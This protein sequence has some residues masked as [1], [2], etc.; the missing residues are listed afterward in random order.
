[1]EPTD[2]SGLLSLRAHAK[3]MIG[4]GEREW[5]ARGFARV[6]ESGVVDVVGCD[7]GRAEGI[8]GALKVIDLVEKADAWFNAHAWSS[9]VVT[10]ASLALSASTPRCLV[11]E[12]KPIANPMQHELVTDPFRHVNGWVAVRRAPGLGVEVDARVLNKYRWD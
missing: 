2:T 1:M 4:T 3:C 6:I 11:F 10:A 7:P 8:T 5:N 9:A 12:M